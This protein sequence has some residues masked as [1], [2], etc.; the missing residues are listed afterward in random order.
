[1]LILRTT[2][3][4]R[5]YYE[6][7]RSVAGALLSTKNHQGGLKDEENESNAKMFECPGSPRCPV[8]TVKNCFLHLNPEA[9]FF[10]QKPRAIAAA[11][12]N[13]EVDKILFCNAS[14]GERTLAKTLK[15]HDNQSWHFSALD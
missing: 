6:I 4:G 2:P 11:K 12:F 14:L 8:E 7:D 15:K 13:P 10:F 9:D 3:S 5:Q 1:M